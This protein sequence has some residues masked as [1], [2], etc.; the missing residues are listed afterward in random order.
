MRRK[1]FIVLIYF[2]FLSSFIFSFSQK[3]HKDYLRRAIYGNRGLVGQEEEKFELLDSA[4][5]LCLD[6]FNGSGVRELNLLKLKIKGFP[7]SKI[8]DIN[9][10][11][12]WM[13]R[14]YTHLGWNHSYTF[15]EAKFDKRKQ[16]LITTCK[17]LYNLDDKEADSFA[18]IVYYIHILA[19]I[20]YE[21]NESDLETAFEN[22]K[23]VRS[24]TIPIVRSHPT[25]G[26]ED[27]IYDLQKYLKVLFKGQENSFNFRA[28]TRE[29]DKCGRDA[30]K[31]VSSAGEVNTIEKFERFKPNINKAMDVLL[32]Y[33]PKLFE[34]ENYFGK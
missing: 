26:N 34:A 15:N 3:E 11:S 29:L 28:L 22:Y 25:E 18:A 33:L 14:R 24:I 32:K 20:I 13:H 5:Y 8:D 16:I 12:N 23:K 21:T 7:I 1:I 19:D 27:V 9:F 17:E 2:I 31:V 4:S 10:R 30:R 6:Q